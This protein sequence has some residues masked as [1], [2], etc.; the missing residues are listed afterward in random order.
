MFIPYVKPK[1]VYYPEEATIDMTPFKEL[2]DSVIARMRKELPHYLTYHSVEHTEMVITRSEYIGKKEGLNNAELRLLK[3]AALYHDFGFTE[4]Y[5]EHERKGCQI[6]QKELP[7]H[8][9]S[10]EQIDM[11]CGMIMATRIPQSPTNLMEQVIADADLEYLGSNKF[12]SIGNRLL[13]ELRYFNSNLT[14]DDWNEIQYKFMSDHH[15]YT[16]YCKRYRQWRKR[17]NLKTIE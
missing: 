14:L 7:A 15:Y 3:T 11:I 5:K 13:E 4:V 1:E 2:K 17:K 10:Q 16:T 9:Y 6:V 8:G 12:V